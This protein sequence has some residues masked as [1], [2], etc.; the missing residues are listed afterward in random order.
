VGEGSLPRRRGY[1]EACRP[2]LSPRGGQ[3]SPPGVQRLTFPRRGPGGRCA[4]AAAWR[5]GPSAAGGDC[6][7]SY[8]PPKKRMK[9]RLIAA[10]AFSTS[11][12]L[13]AA[14]CSSRPTASTDVRPGGRGSAGSEGVRRPA[15]SVFATDGCAASGTSDARC[16]GPPSAASGQ[17]TNRQ[18]CQLPASPSGGDSPLGVV[19]T[20]PARA[21]WMLVS[22]GVRTPLTRT[23]RHPL[24]GRQT[25]VRGPYYGNRAARIAES[26]MLCS[27]S[28]STP[29]FVASSSSS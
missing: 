27:V 19:M 10:K 11:G 1:S 5:L 22:I 25:S 3:Q 9:K 2:R 26:K 18:A 24:S 15:G 14:F 17:R 16:T 8:T 23:L 21:S 12:H 4:S 7:W 28:Y 13:T 29:S 20:G 6:R